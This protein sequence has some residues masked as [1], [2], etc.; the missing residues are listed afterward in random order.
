MTPAELLV[1]LRDAPVSASLVL[2]AGYLKLLPTEVVRAFPRAVLNIHPAPL[3]AF[4]GKGMYGAAVHSAVLASRSP[5]SGPTVHFVDEGYDTGPTL[6]WM[7]VPV[8]RPEDTPASL[9]A[10]VLAAEWELYPVAVAAVVDGRVKW[11]ADGQPI[12]LRV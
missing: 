6:A 3:P 11:A 4:G 1:K 2:L 9:A 12:R 10:R 5:V 7:E 8:H